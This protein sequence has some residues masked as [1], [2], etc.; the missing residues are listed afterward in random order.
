MDIDR[1]A[2]LR[3]QPRLTAGE[4][5]LAQ[6]HTYA[7]FRLR[8]CPF[9][10]FEIVY[11]LFDDLAHPLDHNVVVPAGSAP[12]VEEEADLRAFAEWATSDAPEFLRAEAG[13]EGSGREGGRPWRS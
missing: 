5:E 10:T 3:E 13:G 4:M 12:E 6:R 9:T 2:R 7:F 11:A 8:P 1:T